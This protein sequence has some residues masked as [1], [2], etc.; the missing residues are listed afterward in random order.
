MAAMN[1]SQL[2]SP[3]TESDF[4][5]NY[6]E[7][8]PF[9]FKNGGHFFDDLLTLKNVDAIITSMSH[10]PFSMVKNNYVIPVHSFGEGEKKNVVI[11]L[12]NQGATIILDN[13]EKTWKPVAELCRRCRSSVPIIRSAIANVYLSPPSSQAFDVH[14]DWQDGFILQ[15][16][17]SKS[18]DVYE[19]SFRFPTNSDQTE[20][21]DAIPS[22][23]QKLFTAIL[24]PGDVLYI[25]RGFP[26]EV[27][28]INELSL[29]ITLTLIPYT[30]GDLFAKMQEHAGNRNSRLREALPVD[31]FQTQNDVHSVRK[32][33]FGQLENSEM[34]SAGIASLERE[35]S[36]KSK[37]DF[38]GYFLDVHSIGTINE[39]TLFAIRNSCIFNWVNEDDNSFAV[40][41]SIGEFRI[42]GVNQEMSYIF[43]AGEFSIHEIPGQ[44]EFSDR[45]ELVS[46]LIKEGLLEVR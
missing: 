27:K 12:Y 16:S 34:V 45:L 42:E 35:I 32:E 38:G 30:W 22:T 7:T 44:M 3:L 20:F 15:I 19:P 24:N 1:L 5:E 28:T 39:R 13:L 4:L 46:T 43:S 25:P 17:G 41:S 10:K 8:K 26:H 2:V 23:E 37:S 31:F 29:H 33:L 21:K 40:T 11:D 14:S 18:W 9:H 36:E 6:W